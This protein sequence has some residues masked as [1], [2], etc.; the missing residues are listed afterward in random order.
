ML[1]IVGVWGRCSQVSGS[2][3]CG[4]GIF[5]KWLGPRE[6]GP[7]TKD[8]DTHLSR[9]EWGQGF[10]GHRCCGDGWSMGDY[11]QVSGTLLNGSG[12]WDVPL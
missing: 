10:G 7:P 8:P 1:W 2:F 3:L 6:Q 11:S 5:L 9:W 4:G 12:T